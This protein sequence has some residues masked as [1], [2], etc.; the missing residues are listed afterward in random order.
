MEARIVTVRVRWWRDPG[1]PRW[2][3]GAVL[4]IL[5]TLPFGVPHRPLAAGDEAREAAVVANMLATGDWRQAALGGEVLYEKPPFFYM[6]VAAAARTLGGLSPLSAR[7]VSVLFAALALAATARAGTALF[8]PRGGFAATLLLAST[9]LF[10]VNAHNCLIDVVLAGCVA[11]GMC[12]FIVRASSGAP[13]WDFWWGLCAAAALLAKGLVGPILLVLLTLPF[14]RLSARRLPLPQSVSAGAVGLPLAAFALWMGVT[15]SAWGAHGL[16]EVLW[17]QH[18]GRFLG[19]HEPGYEHHRAGFFYYLFLLPALVFPWTLLF[20]GG[21]ARAF[22]REGSRNLRP[23]ASG[24]LLALVLLSVAGT[25]RTVYLLPLTPVAALLG[26]G[27]LEEAGRRPTR[28][29]RLL[30]RTQVAVAA[31]GLTAVFGLR[32]LPLSTG[33]PDRERRVPPQAHVL[34]YNVNLDIL[35]KA[36]IEMRHPAQEQYSV[37][38]AAQACGGGQTFVLSEVEHLLP[39]HV[40]LLRELLAPVY[41]GEVGGKLMALYRCRA[42]PDRS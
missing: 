29:A 31:A 40:A 23:L 6:S 42:M 28:G 1:S 7:L 32:L 22:T 35:G 20:G 11:A 38:R 21:L 3:A 18:V 41:V 15:W 2:T 36:L 14:W 25:K 26:A 17:V 10:A 30:L 13:R 37:E 33:Q 4:F 34:A 9:Y 19:F 5:L 27:Y 24:F 12:A 8:G 39:P 16:Y